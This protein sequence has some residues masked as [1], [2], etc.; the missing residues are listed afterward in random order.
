MSS[1]L[2]QPPKESIPGVLGNSNRK[3]EGIDFDVSPC[4][5]PPTLHAADMLAPGWQHIA[6]LQPRN[7]EKSQG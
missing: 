1:W 2:A 6:D 4:H 7:P 5:K 3:S